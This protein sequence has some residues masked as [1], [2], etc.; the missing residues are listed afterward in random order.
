MRFSNLFGYVIHSYN[1]I[2]LL[3][4]PKSQSRYNCLGPSIYY[5]PVVDLEG[6][7]GDAR[8]SLFF[9]KYNFYNVK[10]KPKF[11]NLKIT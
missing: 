6:G 10:L 4:L 5:I 9:R 11:V 8:S 7:A 1:D 3:F 2:V